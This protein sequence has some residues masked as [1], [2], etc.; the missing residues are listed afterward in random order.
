MRVRV[1]SR[2]NGVGLSRDLQL[3][4]RVLRDAGVDTQTVGF[5]GSQLGNRVREAGLL[6]RRALRGPVDTQLF[7]ER[8]YQRCLPLA[9]HNLLMP[10]PEWFLPKWRP[11]LPRFERVLCK[12]HHA[13]AI[14][15]ALGCRT[16]YTG[17]TSEDR[18]DASVVREDAFFHLAGRSTAKG[19]AVLLATWRQHP[20]WPR[21]TVVQHPKVATPAA[22]CANIDHRIDYLDDAALQ[23]LQNAHRFHLCPSEAEGFGHYLMEAMAIGAVVLATDAAPMNELV[24][25]QRGVLIPVARTR[26]EGLVDHALV[27]QGG[28]EQAVERALALTTLERGAMGEAARRFFLDNDRAFRQRLPAACVS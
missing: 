13:E 22:P 3:I 12:T 28:I 17:F 1:I 24:T 15:A 20:E 21:L 11:W 26:R 27:D 8:V 18:R 5:G 14:F 10:N 25:P 16:A 19:T 23:R 6:A 9:R 2:D 4:A 7:V